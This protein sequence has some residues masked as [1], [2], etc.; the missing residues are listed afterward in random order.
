MCADLIPGVQSSP[1]GARFKNST[2]VHFFL[3]LNGH[4]IQNKFYFST[5]F[6]TSLISNFPSSVVRQQRARHVQVLLDQVTNFVI[7]KMV[8][9]YCFKTVPMYN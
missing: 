5:I 4:Y 1:Q 9:F 2:L 8:C 6:E 3:E 7:L